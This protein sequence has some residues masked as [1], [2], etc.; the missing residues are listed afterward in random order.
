MHGH[1]HNVLDPPWSPPA[2]LKC[3]VPQPA[4]ICRHGCCHVVGLPLSTSG[5]CSCCALPL[6]CSSLLFPLAKSHPSFMA[7]PKFY[8]LQGPCPTLDLKSPVC[9]LC[10]PTPTSPLTAIT[11]CWHRDCFCVEFVFSAAAHAWGQGPSCILAEG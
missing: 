11:L 10:A 1:S 2:V 9:L 5:L 3:P 6:K 8:F 4:R 7:Q